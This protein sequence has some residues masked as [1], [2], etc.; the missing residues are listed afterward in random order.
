M[1]Y[2]N[3]QNLLQNAQG[4]HCKFFHMGEGLQ[5]LKE[6]ISNSKIYM[7]TW[8][9]FPICVCLYVKLGAFT[10]ITSDLLQTKLVLLTTH[11]E[12]LGNEANKLGMFSFRPDAPAVCFWQFF[13]PSIKPAGMKERGML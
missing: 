11:S 2:R 7:F 4:V 5:I 9:L 3:P 8:F 10:P 13:H 6:L 1:I 12:N